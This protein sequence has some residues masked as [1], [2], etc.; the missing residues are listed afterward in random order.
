MVLTPEQTDLLRQYFEQEMGNLNDLIT[1]KQ[2]SELTDYV[3]ASV[4]YWC[5]QKKL[6]AFYISSKYFIPKVCAVEFLAS[7]KAH[8]IGQKSLKHKLLIEDFFVKNKIK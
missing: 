1:T 3:H 8:C 5:N 6:K 2:L 7:P 4:I